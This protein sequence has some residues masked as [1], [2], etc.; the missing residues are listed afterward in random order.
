MNEIKIVTTEDGSHSLFN[1][2]LKEGYHSFHGALQE[3]RHV[4][5]KAG[6]NHFY[7]ENNVNRPLKVLEVGLGTGLNALLAAE[8]AYENKLEVLMTSYETLPVSTEVV[9][10]LNYP[11]LLDNKKAQRW[12]LDIHESPWGAYEQVD[13][14]YK[15][16]KIEQSIQDAELHP[17]FDVIFFD[18]FAPNKQ[19]EMWELEI[20]KKVTNALVQ[21]GVFVT[22][23]AKGQLKRDL[24]GLGL[25]L[26]TLDGP[27]GK[28]EMTRAIKVI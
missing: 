17:E 14:F 20:I 11:E 10:N 8:W 18:A 1:K 4:F 7:K 16:K 13:E 15:L 23:C 3:S 9:A 22:Y 2:S 25:K 27:P 26:E 5:I 21:S 24:K 12:L 19:P 28:K 6:L